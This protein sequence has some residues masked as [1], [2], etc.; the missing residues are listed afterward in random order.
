[1]TTKQLAKTLKQ[2][3]KGIV[4][5]PVEF[6]GELTLELLDAFRIARSASSPRRNWASIFS[7]TSPPSTTTRRHRDGRR[8]ITFMATGIPAIYD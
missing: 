5:G 8:C 3:F 7:S 6:R 4:S 1:M 2:Q